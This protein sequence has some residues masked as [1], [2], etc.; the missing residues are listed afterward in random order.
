MVQWLSGGGGDQ[1]SYCQQFLGRCHERG[2]PLSVKTLSMFAIAAVAHR[3]AQYERP[4]GHNESRL[5]K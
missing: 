2:M 3:M 1:V 5:D 4:G